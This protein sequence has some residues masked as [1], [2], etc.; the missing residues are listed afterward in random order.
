LPLV[1]Y[2]IY[3][4]L[5]FRRSVS[6]S[7]VQTMSDIPQERS[8]AESLDR[9]SVLAICVLRIATFA[10]FV[11]WA[12]QHLRWSV[13]YD[14]VLWHP[15]Y[16]G[17]LA[18]RLDVSW[19][20]YVAEIMTDR[21]ILFAVRAVGV[22]YLAIA[23]L[24]LRATRNALIS[25][26]SLAVG[27]VLLA[28]LF[29]C[30]YVEAGHAT[31]NFVEHGGQILA[32][33]VLL[34]SLR[35]GVRDRWTIGLA[36]IAFWTTFA[37]HGIYAMGLAPTPG[38]FYGLVN[39]ILGFG[40]EA[41]E[42]LLRIAGVMDFV[43]CLGILLKPARTCCLAYAVAWGLLTA[44]ARPVAGMSFDADWWGADQFL[45]KAILRLPHAAI[46]LFLIA[47]YRGSRAVR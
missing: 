43:I 13:P 33:L 37:G 24:S 7:L 29:F 17:W 3:T 35:R 40:P 4:T 14:A 11:G 5:C 12:W 31:V 42:R 38:H 20:T 21:R 44:L 15:D 6:P 22:M 8:S 45:H 9:S 25:T 10:C 34:I 28:W 23:I 27:S 32:P 30:K 26:R 2:V 36:V 46:P 47:A 18:E 16:F 41:S 1:I 19:E 39:A